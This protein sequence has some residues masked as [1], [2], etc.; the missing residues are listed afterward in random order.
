MHFSE[1][2]VT[3]DVLLCA[4]MPSF[5]KCGQ[6]IHKPQYLNI[7]HKQAEKV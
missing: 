7:C 3:Q 4:I 1:I 2:D 6:I 5:T